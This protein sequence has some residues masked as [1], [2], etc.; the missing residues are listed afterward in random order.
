MGK[1]I[2]HIKQVS[3][4]WNLWLENKNKK[5]RKKVI[6][7]TITVKFSVIKGQRQVEYL[8][9]TNDLIFLLAQ[10]KKK[11]GTYVSNF[12]SSENS[13]TTTYFYNHLQVD[14]KNWSGN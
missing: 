6:Q 9:K 5:K 12:A 11:S 4:L 13:K 3:Q 8:G 1:C 14:P 10:Q 7:V 2:Y